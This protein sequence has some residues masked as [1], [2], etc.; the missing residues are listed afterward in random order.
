MRSVKA[1]SSNL[2]R[3]SNHLYYTCKH[4]KNPLFLQGF[5]GL[6]CG[7]K[8]SHA[9]WPIGSNGCF[10]EYIFLHMASVSIGYRVW[11]RQSTPEA[12]QA[13]KR[14]KSSLRY[15]S[16]AI[17]IYFHN[18][19]C[20]LLWANY[21]DNFNIWATDNWSVGGEWIWLG[22]PNGMGMVLIP[23]QFEWPS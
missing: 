5:N 17:P 4:T 23:L 7:A 13:S 6:T 22:N 16:C 21:C 19:Q 10:I 18:H 3:E 15:K 2:K 9:R 1:R 14:G 12:M 20:G 11:E 8:L